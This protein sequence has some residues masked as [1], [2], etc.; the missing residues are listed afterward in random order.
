MAPPLKFQAP[1]TTIS[2]TTQPYSAKLPIVLIGLIV[3]D[4]LYITAILV[5]CYHVCQDNLATNTISSYITLNGQNPQI[6]HPFG[7][8]IKVRQAQSSDEVGC[9]HHYSNLLI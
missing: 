3:K 2:P 6:K 1:V 9:P 7:D 4:T 5:E 8:K